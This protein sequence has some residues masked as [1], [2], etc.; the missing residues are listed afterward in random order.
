[1]QIFGVVG[2]SGMGKTTL[3]ERLIP[4]LVQ[5]G[6]RVSLVKHSHKSI[7][8][9]RPGKD[10]YRLREAGCDDVVIVG[11]DRWAVVHELRSEPEPDFA[12]IQAA[13]RPCDLLLVE[14]M[15]SVGFPK[16]EV[17][18]PGLDRMPLCKSLPGVAAIASDQAVPDVL[19]GSLHRLRLDDV[20]GIADFIVHRKE[21][22]HTAASPRLSLLPSTPG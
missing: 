18:R 22:H 8:V 20:C 13:I 12:E 19:V 10:S 16:L 2:H 11:R 14:G 21:S 6:L 7:D 3:L 4:E 1:M 15:K 9:D 5:R 17:W